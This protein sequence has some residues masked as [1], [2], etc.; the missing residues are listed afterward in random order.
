MY[1]RVV[2][3]SLYSPNAKYVYEIITISSTKIAGLIL[4]RLLT[5]LGWGVWKETASK[6]LRRYR[7]LALQSLRLVQ[8]PSYV[9]Q[10]IIRKLITQ[11]MH[12]NGAVD[13]FVGCKEIF[14]SPPPPSTKNKLSL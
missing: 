6:P 12:L 9:L 11:P 8:A 7:F 5:S 3:R 2:K 14:A 4:H 13:V 10:R 1:S